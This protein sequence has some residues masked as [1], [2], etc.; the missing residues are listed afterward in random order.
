MKTQILLLSLALIYPLLPANSIPVSGSDPD[1]AAAV[2]NQAGVGVEGRR[3]GGQT[4]TDC[5]NCQAPMDP[6]TLRTG[7][8][9]SVRDAASG[10]PVA[11]ADIEVADVG[12]GASGID[13]TYSV[14]GYRETY[15]SLD[16][17][18]DIDVTATGYAAASWQ[19]YLP[20]IGLPAYIEFDLVPLAVVINEVWA[21][22]PDTDDTGFVE[23]AAAPGLAL[24]GYALRAFL[25]DCSR[26]TELQLSGLTMPADGYFVIGYPDTANVDLIDASWM[27][28]LA[29]SACSGLELLAA[30]Q[31]TDIVQWGGDSGCQYTCGADLYGQRPALPLDLANG[32]GRFP[33]GT[34]PFCEA[35][36][37]PGSANQACLYSPTPTATPL[38]PTATPPSPTVPPVTGTPATPAP[39]ATPTSSPAPTET[40]C[41]GLCIELQA[42]SH[43]WHEGEPWYLD[44]NVIA[45]QTYTDVRVLVY[46]LTGDQFWWWPSW[47]T[48][49]DWQEYD[50]LSGEQI[51]QILGEFAMPD[52]TFMGSD[53]IEFG[54]VIA[55]AAFHDVSNRSYY[56]VYCADPTHTPT[57]SPTVTLTPTATWTPTVTLTP[58]STATATPTSTP[59]FTPVPT[60]TPLPE[61]HME[62]DGPTA[63]LRPGTLFTLL[64]TA[65]STYP[66]TLSGLCTVA[67]LDIGIGEYWFWPGWVPYPPNVDCYPT[68]IP[69]GVTEW[70][71][72]QLRVPELTESISGRIY[73][74]VLDEQMTALSSD[75]AT[76]EFELRP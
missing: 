1:G 15:C 64:L 72:L 37:S 10:S 55:D 47:N 12:H 8:L 16:Y 18:L 67:M 22:D 20:A 48:D 45:A 52:C 73:G 43:E 27:D 33:D 39:T 46:M 2:M 3:S 63:P 17:L 75:L 21:D 74:A 34:G 5:R 24:D 31:R 7:A 65:T 50:E 35:L 6:C 29:D 70:T 49:L 4:D 76:W 57:S 25:P 54:A 30:G 66:D 14:T 58:T 23:L 38:T 13:G 42:P 61:I 44:L 32:L 71:I 41:P 69:P 28:T 53:I 62:F 56:D 40:P 68:A 19:G 11:Y 60:D 59:T 26:Q 9:G 36:V 51:I